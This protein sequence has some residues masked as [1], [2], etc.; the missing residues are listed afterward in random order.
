MAGRRNATPIAAKVENVTDVSARPMLPEGVLAEMR[1][2]RRHPRPTQFDYLHLRRLADDLA[3]AL[4]EVPP[5]V[6]DILD[7]F[8]GTRPYDDLL[9]AGARTIG[10]DIDEHY[11]PVDVATHEFLPFEDDSFDLVICIEAFHFVPDPIHGVAEIG[12]VLRP[13]GTALVTIPFMWEYDRTTL[14]HRFTEPELEQLF[15]GWDDVAVVENGSRGVS[16]ALLTGRV[17]NLAEGGVPKR[18]RGLTGPLFAAVYA[19][20]NAIGMLIEAADVRF[21]RGTHRL[22]M[23]LLLTARNPG[24]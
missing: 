8:C 9:P 24:A 3:R 18:M 15:A 6:V 4:R 2:T 21:V 10:L 12:R 7:V 20:I 22:P 1:R 23:N 5:G 19:A 14:E 17:L 13:G 11:G 16:W